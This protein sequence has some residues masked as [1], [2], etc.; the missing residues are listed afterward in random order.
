LENEKTYRLV[1]SHEM[2]ALSLFDAKTGAILDVNDAWVAL[3]GYAREE[4]LTMNVTDV[5]A[6]P[7]D[8][9]A[10]MARLEAGGVTRVAVRWHRAKDGAVFPVE[11]T[12]G[13]LE[14]GGRDLMYASARDIA[15]RQNADRA[16]A[17]TAA[18]FR[19]LIESTPDSVIVHRH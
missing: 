11:L 6:E 19:A 14:V 10:R 2:D 7:A 1:F 17:R 8:T 9:R 15:Y 3:Y 13:R 5:S 16:L 12:A 18:S 4:A